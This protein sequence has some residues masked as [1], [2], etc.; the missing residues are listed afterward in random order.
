MSQLNVHFCIRH[1]GVVKTKHLVRYAYSPFISFCNCTPSFNC[2][3]LI[4]EMFILSLHAPCFIA[5]LYIHVWRSLMSD[6]VAIM[7]I[8]FE[9]SKHDTRFASRLKYYIYSNF[10]QRK[11]TKYL[12][13]SQSFC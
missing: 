5:T 6:A 8:M 13:P 1:D 2:Q 12:F 9:I 4:T 7:L 11:L 10:R 3:M